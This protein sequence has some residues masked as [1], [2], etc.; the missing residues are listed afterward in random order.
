MTAEMTQAAV[1]VLGSLDDAQRAKAVRT[2]PDDEDRRAWYYTPGPRTGLALGEMTPA[3]ATDVHRLLATALSMSGYAKATAIC[4]LE[5]VL[6]RVEGWD[7][8][9]D[10]SLYHL[11]VF[12]SPGEHAWGWRFEGHHVSVNV[13]L[14]GDEVASTPLFLGANPAVVPG[15]TRPLG[16]EEDAARDLLDTLGPTQLELAV[17]AEEAPPDILTSNHPA[18]D[19]AVMTGGIPG[20][21]LRPDQQ[22]LLARLVRVYLDRLPR[23][24]ADARYERME[25]ERLSFAWAGPAAPGRRHYYRVWGPGFLAEYDNTQDDAN[26]IHAVMRDPEGDFGEDLLRAHL[27]EEH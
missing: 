12:G 16:D 7:R 17:V 2:F 18:V 6:D 3:Q 23:A 1:R 13:A 11:T 22:S 10:P 24:L 25:V 19:P 15:A 27:R 4:A 14:V 5:R 8:N 9:R 26:H 20:G 21:V